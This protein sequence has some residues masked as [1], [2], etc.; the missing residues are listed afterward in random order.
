MPSHVP[1]YTPRLTDGGGKLW[2]RS[3]G[4]IAFSEWPDHRITRVSKT[5]P[6]PPQPVEM[7]GPEKGENRCSRR[8]QDP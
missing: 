1:D 3:R 5:I 2:Y 7:G 6:L 8:R 4:V